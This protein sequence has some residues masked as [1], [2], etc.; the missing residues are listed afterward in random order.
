MERE[1]KFLATASSLA[2]LCFTVFGAVLLVIL[3]QYRIVVALSLVGTFELIL[4]AIFGI[5]F[6][7]SRNEQQL[8]HKRV[9]HNEYPLDGHG[10][11]YYMPNDAQIYPPQAPI[12]QPYQYQPY[13]PSQYDQYQP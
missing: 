3:W 7:R 2:I 11:P 1:Y 9:R 6:M 10:R 5:G 8:R 4:L 13:Q 12:D